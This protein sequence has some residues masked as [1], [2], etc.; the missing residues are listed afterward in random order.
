MEINLGRRCFLSPGPTFN[1]FF[2]TGSV[3]YTHLDV[4]KRQILGYDVNWNRYIQVS[5]VL[6]CT[7]Y[8]EFRLNANIFTVLTSLIDSELFISA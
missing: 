1:I 6:L 7:N 5:L 3:S 8:L 2:A 4:Y